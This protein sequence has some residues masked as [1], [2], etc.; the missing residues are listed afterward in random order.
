M[1]LQELENWKLL[2]EQ[3]DRIEK[4]VDLLGRQ[5]PWAH[6]FDA[7]HDPIPGDERFEDAVFAFR[8]DYLR[9]QSSSDNPS[10]C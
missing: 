6:E 5:S 3:M 1:E 7:F 9:P 10:S 4:K 8:P 2:K